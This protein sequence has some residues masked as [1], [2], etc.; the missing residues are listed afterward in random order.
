LGQAVQQPG[1]N[2]NA[3]NQL[4]QLLSSL[5]NQQQIQSHPQPGGYG[6]MPPPGYGQPQQ[7]YKSDLFVVSFRSHRYRSI[8]S[9]R[10]HIQDML[11]K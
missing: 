7:K 4:N 8:N 11:L 9:S 2:P 3:T 6:Q 10:S 5:I 1:V